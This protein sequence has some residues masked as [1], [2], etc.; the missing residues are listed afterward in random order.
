MRTKWAPPLGLLQILGVDSIP[1]NCDLADVVEKILGE[2]LHAG[3]LARSVSLGPRREI[4][5]HDAYGR[6]RKPCTRGKNAED[7]AEVG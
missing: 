6:K 5:L 2:N 7:V 4:S 3:H 1:W